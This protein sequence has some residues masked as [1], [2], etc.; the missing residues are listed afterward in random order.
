MEKKLPWLIVVTHGKMGEGLIG[1][2]EMICGEVKNVKSISL[3][4]EESPEQLYQE[5]TEKMEGI[6]KE[7]ALIMVDL[8]GG[9]PCNVCARLAKDGFRVVSG[10]N[11]PIF[12]A[13][14]MARGTEDWD[15]VEA[16]VKQVGEES[17]INVTEHI[18]NKMAGRR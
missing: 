15:S 16:S 18:M 2:A 10:V 6:E 14:D 7:E 8:F 3:M 4:P 12:M 1:A 13:A 11:L 5:L 9:T 17:I